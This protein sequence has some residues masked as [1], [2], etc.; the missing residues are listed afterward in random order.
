MKDQKEGNK[1]MKTNRAVNIGKLIAG[2]IIIFVL[3]I[4]IVGYFLY[5]LLITNYEKELFINSSSLVETLSEQISLTYEIR[6][7]ILQEVDD[8]NMSTARLVLSNKDNLSNDYL[9]DIIDIMNVDN[10]WYYNSAGVIIYDANNQYIGWTAQVGDA[11]Y[12]FMTSGLDIFIEEIRPGIDIDGYVKNVFIRADDGSFVEVSTFLTTI[13]ARMEAFE[14]QKIIENY[15]EVHD[16]LLYALIVNTDFIAIADT[17]VNDIGV[18]YSGDEQYEETLGGVTT[19]VEW[20]YDKIEEM[21][22][23]ITA[24]IHYN[25]QIIGLIGVGVSLSSL[26]FYKTTTLLAILVI[27]LGAISLF[28]FFQMI[29]IRRPLKHLNNFLLSDSKSER[30]EY[31][32]RNLFYGLYNTIYQYIDTIDKNNEIILSNLNQT[33]YI[34]NHDYLTDLF[35]R[36]GFLNEMDKW[37]KKSFPFLILFLDLNMFKYYNDLKG[38]AFGDE[39]LISLSNNLKNVEFNDFIVARYGGDEFL[40]AFRIIVPEDV[41]QCINLIT[42]LFNKDIVIDL[43]KCQLSV[44]IGVS[45]FPEDG[46]D[47]ETIIDNAEKA[48]QIA[49]KLKTNKVVYYTQSIKQDILVSSQIVETL[50]EC[51]EN[52]GFEMVYQPIYNIETESI[53]SLE[54]LLRIKNQKLSP[55]IFIPIAEKNGLMN[56]IGRIVIKKVIE[57]AA[58]WKEENYKPL[59]VYINFSETQLYDQTIIEFIETQLN[60]HKVEPNL[61]GIEIT[62][63]VFIDREDRVINSLKNLRKLGI[64]TAIDDFGSGHAGVN[65]LTKFEVEYVKIDKLIADKYLNEDNKIIYQ[66]I[67]NLCESLGFE[68]IAEGIET[69]EQIALLKELGITYVQG[70][71]FSKPLSVDKIQDKLKKLNSR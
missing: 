3:F 46:E 32:N 23:E 67:F 57:Q 2:P 25:D 16:E 70:Y 9:F 19:G 66:T 45:I 35:N 62:E 1:N 10:I 68:L 40:I 11:I 41:T 37:M 69:A 21:I 14:N 65:Y 58:I 20:Y 6:D 13:E 15:I 36:R 26:N 8:N 33:R 44:S 34:S 12:N 48:M 27:A 31:N 18:D 38:H 49:K 50:R 17:N 51:I 60:Q 54:A 29:M 30:I 39:L 63:D 22:Y 53:V 55:G 59:M 24:P 5:S 28:I 47:V 71:Y 42:D 56:K 7:Q 52:D 43:F 4:G 61:I 64:H